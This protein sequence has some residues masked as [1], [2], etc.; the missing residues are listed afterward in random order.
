MRIAF[1]RLPDDRHRV[2][3]T[4]SDGTTDARE[5]DS[6]SFVRHDLV[7]YAVERELGL[8]GGFWGCVAGGASLSGDGVT[9]AQADLAEALAGPAQTLMR[10][11]AGPEAYVAL[12]RRVVPDR[13]ADTLGPR[14]HERVRRLRGQWRATP[15]HQPLVLEWPAALVRT[16]AP[17]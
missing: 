16:P 5:L 17:G 8:T 9:G 12:L 4:R 1:Q 11:Q 3:V 10:L 15:F 13:D 6:R 7:H 2:S 14:V